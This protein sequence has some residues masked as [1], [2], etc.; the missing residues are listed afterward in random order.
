MD[1]FIIVLLVGI[2]LF[3]LY[4]EFSSKDNTKQI[5]S[6]AMMKANFENLQRD[7]KS[8]NNT[9]DKKMSESQLSFQRQFHHTTKIV[10][11]VTKK[12]TE[13]DAT[14]KQVVG[15]A[16]QMKSLENILKNPKQRG[17]LGEYFLET[18]L[19][20]S[21]PPAGY[22]LQYSFQDGTI[23]DAAIFVKK[24]I[25]SV[26]AKFSLE[27]YNRIAEETD[28][29]KR[30]ELEKAMKRDL[31]LRIDETSKYIKPSEDTMDFALMFIP[32][33]GIFYNL[34]SQKVGTLDVN[35][36][37]LIKYAF[38]KKVI[39]VSPMTFFAY[40]Q[41]IM[42]ALKN[43]Q[44]EE[45]VKDV[46]KNVEKLGRHLSSYEEYLQKIGNNLGTT[47]N[48]YNKAYK[49]FEKVDKDVMKISGA[50]NNIKAIDVAKPEM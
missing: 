31:K 18:L 33:D 30:Q 24:K 25:I 48:M 22:K 27:V 14:N 13:L 19:S 7:F 38:S 12:L 36:Q 45:S 43:M 41:T 44:I 6:F 9:L 50:N 39:I 46:I 26:D 3:L 28:K 29:D 5:E 20:H 23:V 47:V 10:E 4:K 11:D 8:F 2:L 40:L 17:I 35:T 37:D 42:Q 32:A 21:L 49:E 34:L 16:E 1:V 15:F